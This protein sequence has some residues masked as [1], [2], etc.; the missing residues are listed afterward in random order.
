MERKALGAMRGIVAAAGA[1]LIVSVFLPW[2]DTTGESTTAWD[3]E[4]GIAVLCVLAGAAALVGA[5]T[6]GQIGL[7]RP[8]VSSSAAADLLNVAAT[9]TVAAF[10]LF[11]PASPAAGAYL[12]LASAAVAACGSAD[13]RVLRGAPLFPR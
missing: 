2:A 13:W 3:L 5:A 12:A 10:V 9:A 11:D 8:D 7:F 1:A 6:N 4:P